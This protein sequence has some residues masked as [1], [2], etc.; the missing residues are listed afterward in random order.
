[1]LLFFTLILSIA[2]FFLFVM[3]LNYSVFEWE[4]KKIQD[5]TNR[6]IKKSDNQNDD[7][8]QK[9]SYS[10]SI[11]SKSYQGSKQIVLGDHKFEE[12]YL[13][14]LQF[15][16]LNFAKKFKKISVE[17]FK[18]LPNLLKPKEERNKIKLKQEIQFRTKKDVGSF[19]SKMG[20][21]TT[22]Q[23]DEEVELEPEILNDKVSSLMK[24]RERIKKEIFNKPLD[25][26][27]KPFVAFTT[28]IPIASS[29]TTTATPAKS[30]ATINLAKEIEGKSE[31]EM[32][33]F[34]KLEN[35]IIDSLKKAD[36]QDW[37]IWLDLA[38]LY[39]KHNQTQKALEI[40]AL[41]LKHGTGR[42]KDM[43]RDGLIALS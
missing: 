16:F 37:K 34:E 24:E 11:L 30:T 19:V 38:L 26:K 36:M 1:M 42:E 41:V 27:E 25:I 8:L 22:S 17:F 33:L 28:K 15:K 5:L 23:L 2:T 35:K 21:K 18:S 32:S 4:N 31:E 40:Y 7:I 10:R 29:S 12:N 39:Q 13:E 43:A 14:N 6:R 9:P 20:K 3:L